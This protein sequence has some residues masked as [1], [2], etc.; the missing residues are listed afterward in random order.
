M[1]SLKAIRLPGAR[2][3]KPRQLRA[4]YRTLLSAFGHQKWWPGRTRFE[5]ILGAI[6]TQNTAWA[7]VERALAILRKAKALTPSAMRKLPLEKLAALIRPSGYF[8]VKAL[9][10]RAFLDFLD[11]DYGGS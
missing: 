10:L 6:L 11:Q 5:I 4:V 3:L 2:P 7:N 9:R 8:N 1:K